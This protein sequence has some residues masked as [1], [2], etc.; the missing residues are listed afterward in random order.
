MSKL[1]SHIKSEVCRAL[2]SLLK[3][4]PN[5]DSVE[6]DTRTVLVENVQKTCY[7]KIPKV[8]SI[9]KNLM[10]YMYQEHPDFRDIIHNE[11]D[12]QLQIDKPKRD[13]P[14]FE[15][16]KKK[17]KEKLPN[18]KGE[19]K[20]ELFYKP[21]ESEKLPKI[22]NEVFSK[23]SKFE[24]LDIKIK[25]LREIEDDSES[26]E[27]EDEINDRIPFKSEI[28]S[29]KNAVGGVTPNNKGE[30]SFRNNSLNN[31]ISSTELK[32][33]IFLIDHPLNEMVKGK[34]WGANVRGLNYLK[35]NEGLN[36]SLLRGS[37]S[38]KNA[39]LDELKQK[40]IL[41]IFKNNQSAEKLNSF[42]GFQF[43][44]FIPGEMSSI[45]F[46]NESAQNLK[47][48][49]VN[50]NGEIKI[51]G[52][53]GK[54]EIVDIEKAGF[55]LEIDK[56]GDKFLIGKDGER[57]EIDE[58]RGIPVH[59]NDKGELS[60]GFPEDFVQ[61]MKNSGQ[62]LLNQFVGLTQSQMRLQKM[63]EKSREKRSQFKKMMKK[64]IK[65]SFKK[66]VKKAK[67]FTFLDRE[68]EYGRMRRLRKIKQG[69]D[70]DATTPTAYE[71]DFNDSYHDLFHK[72]L[73]AKKRATGKLGR[74]KKKKKKTNESDS[75]DS[76]VKNDERIIKQLD[77]LEDTMMCPKEEAEKIALEMMID[78]YLKDGV[79][80][81]KLKSSHIWL[82]VLKL[83][84]L[85]DFTK[86]FEL[87]FL[88]GDDMYILRACIICGAK[89]L[90]KVHKRTGGKIIKKLCEIKLGGKI[91]KTFLGF[92][93]KGVRKNILEVI[94]YEDS[95]MTLHALECISKQYNHTLKERAL[96]ML[97]VTKEVIKYS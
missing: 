34:G 15:I 68:E 53:D 63:R 12:N 33:G 78:R 40:A 69:H 21:R 65:D 96:Y 62:K 48:L 87:L 54:E 45:P 57:V 32:R 41:E 86:A 91:P 35:K 73:E 92:I 10:N 72:N 8:R 94:G 84:K 17:A 79:S 22:Q 3:L 46:N 27:L 20:T 95:V 23:P 66:G 74:K 67:K 52:I 37:Q 43:E 61:D 25:N 16:F 49:T 59:I 13:I 56:N 83:I 64:N 51:K 88:F 24:K 90:P 2:Q 75:S 4:D 76:D 28:E 36:P 18:I 26:K 42:E 89:I 9:A 29:P 30:I 77:K 14:S 70:P 58:E 39:S 7:S 82:Y 85:E 6:I 19:V 81:I 31:I 44:D 60:L 11:V 97:E 47:K 55:K 38:E 71:T 50:E 5:P 1:E 93:E 80:S